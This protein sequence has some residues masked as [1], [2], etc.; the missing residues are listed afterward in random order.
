MKV[1]G[2]EL[3]SDKNKEL[4]D[5]LF[6]F[7]IHNVKGLKKHCRLLRIERQVVAGFNY[8]VLLERENGVLLRASLFESI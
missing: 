7:L 1:G 4:Y 8:R 5:K 2:Y 3:V 6:T